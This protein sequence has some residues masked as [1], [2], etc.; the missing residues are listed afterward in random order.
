METLLTIMGWVSIGILAWFIW[1]WLA[2]MV[3]GWKKS[4]PRITENVKKDVY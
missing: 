1:G 3:R 2:G 4:A